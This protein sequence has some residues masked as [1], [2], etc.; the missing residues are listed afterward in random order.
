M[1]LMNRNTQSASVTE[2]ME[3]NERSL[4]VSE[5]INRIN[6]I[7]INTKDGFSW[8]VWC[9]Q[10]TGGNSTDLKMVSASEYLQYVQSAVLGSMPDQYP[11]GFDAR[12]SIIHPNP[13]ILNA[14]LSPD[15]RYAL[16]CVYTR[17]RDEYTHEPICLLYLLE[18]ET[19]EIRPVE[20]PEGTV[21]EALWT[22]T[23]YGREYRPGMS[24]NPDGTI[25]LINGKGRIEFFRL[26]VEK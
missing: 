6:L 4:A 9:L 16:L 20:A 14:C 11:E 12:V 5:I 19:M 15:G 3:Q 8:D 2:Q 21:S 17:E 25:I 10:R 1:T 24:W 23:A 26:T 7:R 18:M 22:N 13:S